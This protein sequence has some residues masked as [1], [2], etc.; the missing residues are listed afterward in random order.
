MK[1]KYVKDGKELEAEIPE[2]DFPHFE[3]KYQAKKVG[4]SAPK[5]V[6]SKEEAPK[7]EPKK[8]SRK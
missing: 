7:A 8:R 2:A 6:E 1:I 4:G 5:K 3:E